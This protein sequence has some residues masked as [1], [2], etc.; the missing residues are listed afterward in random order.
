[1]HCAGVLYTH[2]SH[3]LLRPSQTITRDP[4]SAP[5]RLHTAHSESRTKIE[6]IAERDRIGVVACQA[7]VLF[8]V[9]QL[10]LRQQ[11][12]RAVHPSLS[13]T[14]PEFLSI[15]PMRSAVPASLPAA[16]RRIPG[17]P[18]PTDQLLQPV[19]TTVHQLMRHPSLRPVLRKHLC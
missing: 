13:A 1:M 10:L 3:S 19:P 11:Q 2:D 7:P 5:L 16:M 12:Q 14:V 15:R 4:E 8:L 17:H 9:I 6:S 18:S